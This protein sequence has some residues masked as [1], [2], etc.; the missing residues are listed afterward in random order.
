MG[1]MK[2]LSIQIDNEIVTDEE[3]GYC[4]ACEFVILMALADGF[5]PSEEELSI[6]CKVCGRDDEQDQS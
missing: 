2:E 5:D 1:L 3:Q 6:T 4:P